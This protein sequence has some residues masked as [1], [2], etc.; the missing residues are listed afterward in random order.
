VTN[1][2]DKDGHQMND[3]NLF[4]PELKDAFSGREFFTKADLRDFY[5]ERYSSFSNPTF[6]RILYTL[7]KRA[8]IIPVDSGV[9]CM[10]NGNY[11]SQALKKYVPNFS[12]ELRQ[13]YSMIKTAFPYSNY[14]VWETS[15]LHEFMLHQPGQGMKIVETEREVAES[16]FNFLNRQFSGRVFLHP[17]RL[18]FE[19]YIITRSDSIIITTLF[20]QSPQQKVEDIPT[21]KLEKILVDVFANEDIFYIFH[22]EELT[23]IFETAFERYH[24]SQKTLFRYAKRRKIDQKIRKFICGTTNIQLIQLEKA[25]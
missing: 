7:E 8:V 16:A 6:R 14:L 4:L 17:D 25:S 24:V 1:Y 22:G 19:R 23:H 15:V 2:E 9:Y 18:T 13:L 12:P 21:A 20:S 10:P 11:P 3:L 5:Q